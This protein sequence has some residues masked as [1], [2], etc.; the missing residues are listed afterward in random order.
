ML[1]SL[2]FMSFVVDL[3]YTWVGGGPWGAGTVCK[4]GCVVGRCIRGVSNIFLHFSHRFE[5]FVFFFC[6]VC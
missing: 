2:F 6:R 4:G 1:F 5:V 3:G